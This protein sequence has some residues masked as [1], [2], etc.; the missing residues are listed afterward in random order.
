MSK[1]GAA[2]TKKWSR[3]DCFAHSKNR[4]EET[5]L[6]LGLQTLAEDNYR[7][8][9]R[10]DKHMAR[11]RES[12][13]GLR[14][15]TGYATWDTGNEVIEEDNRQQSAH[16]TV[17]FADSV[18]MVKSPRAAT[19]FH[20]SHIR[21]SAVR[22]AKPERCTL[23]QLAGHGLHWKPQPTSRMT[24]SVS[25]ETTAQI[26]AKMA[27]S[28]GTVLL[29]REA[30]QL[31]S[32]FALEHA[33]QEALRA[34]GRNVFRVRHQTSETPSASESRASSY[35]YDTSLYDS[36]S[37]GE[38]G[39]MVVD[40]IH[41]IPVV[42][43]RDNTSGRALQR[44]D[45][46]TNA[47]AQGDQP[48]ID[49]DNEGTTTA[50]ASAV[51]QNVTAD[52]PTTTSQPDAETTPPDNTHPT[53]NYYSVNYSALSMRTP[54]SVGASTPSKGI[55]GRGT[56]SK[57][58]AVAEQEEVNRLVHRSLTDI[59]ADRK[60][61][62]S[63]QSRPSTTPG[64]GRTNTV[65]LPVSRYLRAIEARQDTDHLLPSA[66]NLRVPI[67][68]GMIRREVT[69]LT[70]QAPPPTPRTDL[71]RRRMDELQDRIREFLD[72]MPGPEES[73]IIDIRDPYDNWEAGERWL[74]L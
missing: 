42:P 47:P 63:N 11:L 24:P 72:S 36:E 9:V 59:L 34:G 15:C 45:S 18:A 39:S 31:P 35:S 54:G 66:K 51:D 7:L 50:P 41:T 40:A 8:S 65:C 2:S 74:L 62:Q 12:L 26:G 32:I 23:N 38:R 69:R 17:T 20:A 6:R 60:Q 25:Q 73:G 68:R 37:E 71:E 29:Q 4:Q 21:N 64:G 61:R 56:L 48:A 22:K 13:T 16:K 30:T 19:A 49:N 53:N 55:I 46:I 28:G 10:L 44:T 70:L 1:S 3:A 67:S 14:A 5:W 27:S 43:T 57:P 52:S 58:Q 33:R